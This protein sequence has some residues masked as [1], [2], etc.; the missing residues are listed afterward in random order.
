MA[1]QQ[2]VATSML[3]RRIQVRDTVLGIYEPHRG[4]VGEIVSVYQDKDREL[5]FSVLFPDGHLVETWAA[6]GMLRNDM[7]RVLEEK[8]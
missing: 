8:A 1:R 5:R 3:G 6:H 7:F 2:P 4:Q